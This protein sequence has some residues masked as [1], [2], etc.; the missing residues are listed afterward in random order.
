MDV[1]KDASSSVIPGGGSGSSA[2][3]KLKA[4]A[5]ANTPTTRPGMPQVSS[6]QTWQQQQT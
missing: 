4:S 3:A 5:A 2:T 6:F 1:V